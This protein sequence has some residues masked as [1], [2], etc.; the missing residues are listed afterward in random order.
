MVPEI[1]PFTRQNASRL[2]N[3]AT[4]VLVSIIFAIAIFG[5]VLAVAGDSTLW[6]AALP[7]AIGLFTSYL[8]IRYALSPSNIWEAENPRAELRGLLVGVILAFAT[9]AAWSTYLCERGWAEFNGVET[10]ASGGGSGF[11]S[12]VISAGWLSTRFQQSRSGTRLGSSKVS[13]PGISWPEVSY[14]YSG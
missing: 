10:V 7:G 12:S 14:S 9:A 11:R 6:G 2:R 1:A 4:D 13:S 5:G 8:L 3:L